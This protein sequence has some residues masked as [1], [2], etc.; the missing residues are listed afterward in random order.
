MVSAWRN[1]VDLQEETGVRIHHREV[2]PKDKVFFF[3]NFSRPSLADS[4]S[5][6]EL[7]LKLFLL[8]LFCALT[9]TR[10]NPLPPPLPPRHGLLRMKS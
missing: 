1:W 8:R 10:T 9:S 3:S 2:I 5:G 7:G 4:F 6:E